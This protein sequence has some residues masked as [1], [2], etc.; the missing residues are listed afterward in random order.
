MKA[1]TLRAATVRPKPTEQ[2]RAAAANNALSA[3]ELQHDDGRQQHTQPDQRHVDIGSQA[4]EAVGHLIQPEAHV[5]R[6]QHDSHEHNNQ[7]AQAG[8]EPLLPEWNRGG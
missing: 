5:G 1:S 4:R 6:D 8:E 3:D 2:I 7:D